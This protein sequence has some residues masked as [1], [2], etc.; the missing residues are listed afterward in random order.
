MLAKLKTLVAEGGQVG[1]AKEGVFKQQSCNA[2][3]LLLEGVFAWIAPPISQYRYLKSHILQYVGI[4][5][6]VDSVALQ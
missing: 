4:W 2:T 3:T 1:A 5:I 6:P